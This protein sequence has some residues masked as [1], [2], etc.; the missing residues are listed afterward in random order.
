MFTNPYNHC[1]KTICVARS[2]EGYLIALRI[3]KQS[4]YKEY[5]GCFS[6]I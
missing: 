3:D 4:S 2:F 1:R 6:I 5:S